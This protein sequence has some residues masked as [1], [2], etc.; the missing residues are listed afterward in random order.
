MVLHGDHGG[1]SIQRAVGVAQAQNVGKL[2]RRGAGKQN[3]S[4]RA[5]LNDRAFLEACAG[6][7]F[8]LCR[9]LRVNCTGMR[10][11]V[12]SGKKRARSATVLVCAA[13]D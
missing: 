2:Q 3:F 1:F 9:L 13:R 7:I 4:R 10:T 6:V 12:A 11:G 8:D 5:E